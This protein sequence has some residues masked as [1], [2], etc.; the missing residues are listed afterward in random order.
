MLLESIAVT[1]WAREHVVLAIRGLL[2][3][4]WVRLSFSTAI[5]NRETLI[6]KTLHLVLIDDERL[7]QAVPNPH[8]LRH[9]ADGGVEMTSE[10]PKGDLGD[11]K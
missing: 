3:T 7:K 8:V 11:K 4:S 5:A 6:G 10:S 2:R 1:V 9:T